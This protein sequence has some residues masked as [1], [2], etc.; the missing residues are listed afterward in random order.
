M[1]P[2]SST[3]FPTP[4]PTPKDSEC[5]CPGETPRCGAGTPK[6]RS[7]REGRAEVEGRNPPLGGERPIE[8]SNEVT[9]LGEGFA[10]QKE[11]GELRFPP[12]PLGNTS[13]LLLS[14]IIVFGEVSKLES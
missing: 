14:L 10:V 3:L 8:K 2:A 11:L 4:R 1:S 5:T 9:V 12:S 6:Q 13:F 7:K